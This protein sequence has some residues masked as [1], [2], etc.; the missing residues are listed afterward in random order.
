MIT[1]AGFEFHGATPLSDEDVDVTERMEEILQKVRHAGFCRVIL[2]DGPASYLVSVF[3]HNV[4][5]AYFDV[6]DM[7]YQLIVVTHDARFEVKAV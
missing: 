1:I 3:L 5:G 2:D 6:F 4:D 7:C